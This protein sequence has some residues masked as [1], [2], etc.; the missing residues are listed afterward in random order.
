MGSI[1]GTLCTL[2]CR[3]LPPTT[4]AP[5]R[6][7]RVKL[8]DCYNDEAD[9]MYG[10]LA[11]GDIGTVVAIDPTEDTPVTVE[12]NGSTF[13][14]TQAALVLVNVQCAVARAVHTNCVYVHWKKFWGIDCRGQTIL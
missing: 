2:S 14:Y 6:G 1:L 5:S 12:A 4:V 9:A 10:P 11:P 13:R 7:D 8:S 3:S